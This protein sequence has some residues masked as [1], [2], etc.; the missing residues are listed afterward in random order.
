MYKLLFSILL[1]IPFAL[2]AMQDSQRLLVAGSSAVCGVGGYL[3]ADRILVQADKEFKMHPGNTRNILKQEIYKNAKIE[4]LKKVTLSNVLKLSSCAAATLI[5]RCA[6]TGYMPRNNAQA[7]ISSLALISGSVICGI[8]V[9]RH[10][11]YVREMGCGLAY[12]NT[13]YKKW[14]MGGLGLAALGMC[15]LHSN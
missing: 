15:G 5:A 3:L 11:M 6:C 1:V 9:A 10:N 7:F 13:R 8:A 4:Y 12:Y 14:F 2:P